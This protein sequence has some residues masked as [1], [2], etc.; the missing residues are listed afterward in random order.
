MSFVLECNKNNRYDTMSDEFVLQSKN[1][2]QSASVCLFIRANEKAKVY[3]D[4][5]S[6]K[7]SA[8]RPNPEL[9]KLLLFVR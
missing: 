9:R 5:Q 2:N 6:S 3:E 8:N 1:I 4:F 7:T